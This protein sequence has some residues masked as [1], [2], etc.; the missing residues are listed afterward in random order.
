MY[1]Q[2]LKQVTGRM[3]RLTSALLQA[4]WQETHATTLHAPDSMS[5]VNSDSLQQK[6][7]TKGK[8][9]AQQMQNM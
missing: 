6:K 9:A 2:V 1:G 5:Q 3:A 4:V 7:T 8:T